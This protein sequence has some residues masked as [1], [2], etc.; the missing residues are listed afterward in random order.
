MSKNAIILFT[1]AFPFGYEESFLETEISYLSKAFDIV[2]IISKN[3][4][5][6]QPR[7]LPNNCRVYR[8]RMQKKRFYEKVESLKYLFSLTL[9]REI[10][11]IM[12]LYKLRLTVHH[13]KL[14]L[15]TMTE[16]KKYS[17]YIEQ[18]IKKE[19]LQSHNI[20]LYAYWF[21]TMAYTIALLKK[22]NPLYCAFTRA[23]GWDLYFERNQLNYLPLR[24]CIF[25][26]LDAI[27]F[28]SDDGKRYFQKRLEIEDNNKLK[29]SRLG[30]INSRP[31]MPYSK[32]NTLKL[33]S[34]SRI[35]PLKRL[36]LLIEALSIVD[37]FQISWVHI[38]SG[39]K[40][41][42]IKQI[43]NSLLNKKPNVYY[44]FLGKF[45]NQAIY[46]YY[47]N[48]PVDLLINVSSFEGIPMSIQEAMSFGIPVIATSV[49]GI[50]EIV[51]EK[52][53]ILLSANP[54]SEEVVAA[55]RRF[56]FMSDSEYASYRDNSYKT[57]HKQYNGDVNYHAFVQDILALK[58]VKI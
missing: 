26:S 28:I 50:T 51:N 11:N 25:E 24:K 20:F 43:A 12:F 19:N 14:L 52:N 23:H 5:D 37:N 8:M 9:L 34:C 44:K 33:V 30:V 17:V 27:F 2:I 22:R 16:G 46:E 42:S 6:E 10:K 38:G 47:S 45:L 58:K 1:D 40:E 31:F 57:W 18:I 15:K 49:G 35:I 55:I 54:S 29:V 7:T 13:V 36:D 53:G 3:H 4:N 41:E 56:Y 21:S 39:E 48:N 32:N